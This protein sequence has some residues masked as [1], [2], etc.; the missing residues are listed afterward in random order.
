MFIYKITNIINN[1]I[2]IGQTIQ[3]PRSRWSRHK[4]NSR[5]GSTEPLYNAIRKYG[6]HSF[7]FEVICQSFT[8]ENLN[9]LEEYFIS[10]YKSTEKSFGYNILSGGNNRTHQPESNLKNRLA[11][12]GKKTSEDTKNKISLKNKGQI[13][14]NIGLSGYSMPDGHGTNVSKSLT[15]KKKSKEHKEK[16]SIARKE[17][18]QSNPHHNN[19]LVICLNTGKIYKSVQEAANEF[20][21]KNAHIA[22]VCRNERNAHKGFKFQYIKE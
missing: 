6:D 7:I 20:K 12:L 17:Y 11:H 1:K 2:Y 14:W 8:L 22:R 19:K 18:Y 4:Y 15:G 3:N 10:L 16:L 9:Y 13:P 21:C 5:V